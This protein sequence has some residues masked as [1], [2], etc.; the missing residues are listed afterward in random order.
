M[1]ADHVELHFRHATRPSA[2]RAA[3]QDV[4]SALS[5]SHVEGSVAG[6]LMLLV[7]ELVTNAVRHARGEAF[8]VRLDVRPERLRLEVRDEGAGFAPRVSPREDG[9]GG[10]G[11][12]IVDQ[13]ADRWGVERDEQGV[14]WLELDRAR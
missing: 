4:R 12:F 2:I 14:V 3:R 13:L 9:T 5:T 10:Y 11:L 6:D 1:T 7:S 8:E